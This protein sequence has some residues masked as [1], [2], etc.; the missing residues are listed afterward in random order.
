LVG[1]I[2]PDQSQEQESITLGLRYDIGNFDYAHVPTMAL[3]AEWQYIN[4][5]GTTGQFDTSRSGASNF[6][7][8]GVSVV[9][10][11]LDFVF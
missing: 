10:V 3:K 11:A 6:T 4:P 9:S 2:L 7:G 8:S 1:G 5:K